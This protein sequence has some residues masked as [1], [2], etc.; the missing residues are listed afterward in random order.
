MIEVFISDLFHLS[1]EYLPIITIVLL[2]SIKRSLL[3]PLI[4]DIVL[5]LRNRIKRGYGELYNLAEYINTNGEYSRMLIATE[6]IEKLTKEQLYKLISEFCKE[7]K[8]EK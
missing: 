8:K 2:L 6:I 5:Y 7:M 3:Y 4:Y 1:K